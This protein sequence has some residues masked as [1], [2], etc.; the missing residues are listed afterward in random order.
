[1]RSI[2]VDDEV[3]EYLQRLAM[4][5]VDKPNDVLRRLL[6]DGAE[7]TGAPPAARPSRRP[8]ALKVFIDANVLMAG[9]ILTFEQPRLRKTHTATVTPDGWIEVDGV[10]FSSPSPALKHCVGHDINGWNWRHKDGLLNTMREKL[11]SR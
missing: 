3:F 8:G 11:E 2:K 9:D 6:L 1:M 10:E 7:A 5:F 4:P